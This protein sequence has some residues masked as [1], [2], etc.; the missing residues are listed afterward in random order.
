VATGTAVYEVSATPL[1]SLS[2]CPG[3][4][5]EILV[6]I[7]QTVQRGSTRSSAP[8]PYAVVYALVANPSIGGLNTSLISTGGASSGGHFA[9]VTFTAQGIGQTRIDFTG[10]FIPNITV[11]VGSPLG[12]SV[13]AAPTSLTVKVECRFAISLYST[14]RLPGERQLDVL[15]VVQSARLVPD[16][17]GHFSTDAT[18]SSSAVWIGGCTGT[19]RIQRSRVNIAGSVGSTILINLTFD[20]VSSVTREGCVGKSRGDQGQA[21][22]LVLTLSSQGG[23]VDL[24]HVLRTYVNAAGNTTVV[25]KRLP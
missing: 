19:S 8:V 5:V 1:G 14:W 15:G 25:L 3:E 10:N 13:P 24:P 11:P 7:D 17:Q 20:P 6:S 2:L 4:S 22:P 9:K 21:D 23:T 18:M 12:G 16:A